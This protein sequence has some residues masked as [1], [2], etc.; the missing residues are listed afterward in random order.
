MKG[1]MK[2][3]KDDTVK[4]L[5]GKDRGKTGKLLRVFAKEGKILVEGINMY[6]R[7]IRK[8]GQHEGGIIDLTKP[9]N[10]SNAQLVC[11]NCKKD[12][13]VSYKIENG[14]KNRICKKCQE[15]IK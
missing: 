11:P 6:K 8:T 5:L 9:I 2:I 7:N 4:I 12:T 15:V 10:I 13:R 3:K 14:I 1:I